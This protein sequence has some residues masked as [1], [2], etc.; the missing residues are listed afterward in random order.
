MYPID[1]MP[2]W[3]K[4]LAYINPLTYAVDGARHFL[5]GEHVAKFALVTDVGV[6]AL[7]A[8]LLVGIAMIEFEKATIG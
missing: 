6:L 1:T 7:L 2:D 3:M 8:F 4:V 5:I